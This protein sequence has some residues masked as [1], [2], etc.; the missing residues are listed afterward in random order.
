MAINYSRNAIGAAAYAALAQKRGASHTL[1]ATEL[2]DLEGD[3]DA[4]LAAAVANGT[5][6]GIGVS[7]AGS[8]AVKVVGAVVEAAI[9]DVPVH[10]ASTTVMTALATQLATLYTAISTV[11]TANA[12]QNSFLS[13]AMAAIARNT[14][15]NGTLTTAVL[16][17][18]VADV[19]TI[20]NACHANATLLALEP[21]AAGDATTQGVYAA[22]E[23]AL[24]NVPIHNAT[25]AE[26]TAIVAR[27]ASLY[28]SI[29]AH[30]GANFI[31]STVATT[32]FMA[33]GANRG[34][35]GTLTV[36]ELADLL[37]DVDTVV[38]TATANATIFALIG[39]AQDGAG[40]PGV[41][42]LTASVRSVLTNTNVRGLSATALTALGTQMAALYT[43]SFAHMGPTA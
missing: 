34:A 37:A 1:T 5:I 13:A 29:A 17:E 9:T 40:T 42:A 31:T 20:F 41:Q 27:I 35:A 6:G 30:F 14:G 16:N 15:V 22:I 21:G 39:G 7:T 8:K 25:P 24:N 11:V 12:I 18:L 3:V 32:A 36:T 10:G 26:I 38:T 28:T 4:T 43:S 2:T 19:T 33:L 23:V